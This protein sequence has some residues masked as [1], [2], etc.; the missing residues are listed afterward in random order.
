M[1]GLPAENGHCNATPSRS[2]EEFHR[3]LAPLER[4][5]ET[6]RRSSRPVP[7]TGIALK[8]LENR[9]L[10]VA[11]DVARDLEHRTR[12]DGRRTGHARE[13]SLQGTRPTAKAFDDARNASFE[14]LYRDLQENTVVVLGGRG[15]VHVFARNGRHVTSAVYPGHV[16][17]GRVQ[18]KRW[19][20]LEEEARQV[21]LR[22]LS[23]A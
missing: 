22:S 11:K 23:P 9:C 1:V 6:Y 15:R 16:I 18:K 4:E 5:I 2:P 3:A 8:R 17:R 21:F 13:R 20:P 12:M 7:R 19:V 14:D 10:S